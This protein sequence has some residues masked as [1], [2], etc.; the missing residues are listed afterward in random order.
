MS[1]A[2]REHRALSGMWGW[3]RVVE[4]QL[5]EE[6]AS[7]WRSRMG[8]NRTAARAISMTAAKWSTSG[9]LL[10][11]PT[12]PPAAEAPREAARL[13]P[14]GTRATSLPVTP[15]LCLPV[16]TCLA[17]GCCCPPRRHFWVQGP[18]CSVSSPNTDCHQFCS[19][20]SSRTRGQWREHPS[21]NRGC[22][23]CQAELLAVMPCGS[24]VVLRCGGNTSR[25]SL[26]F[27]VQK[28]NRESDNWNAQG[29]VGSAN[30]PLRSYSLCSPILPIQLAWVVI[31]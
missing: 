5:L 29:Q 21:G 31:L 25:A 30:S 17:P 23:L 14:P 2:T 13:G 15:E 1:E 10:P 18:D 22:P 3:R 27:A 7:E 9:R 20:K 26:P 16:W 8:P 11:L 6:T 4:G 12:G 28:G 24:V 19:F